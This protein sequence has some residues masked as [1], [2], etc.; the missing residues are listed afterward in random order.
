M[1]RE[2]LGLLLRWIHIIAGIMWV[3]DSLLFMW[4]DSHLSPDPQR[5]SEV[6]GVTWLIHGGGYYH[7]EK[8]LLVPGR[9]PPRL[10]W[11]WLEA[12]STWLSGFLLLILIYYMSADAYLIDRS[13]SSI[14]PAAAT[15]VGVG[16]IVGGW[17]LYYGLW[18]TP[19]V[20]RPLILL[21]LSL[22]LLAAAG[23]LAT[24]VLSARAA[25]LHIGAMLG[26]IMAANVWVHI[27]PPQYRMVQAARAG[28]EIDY[29]LGVHA[30]TRS[31]H[32]TYFTFPV[33]F[34]MISQHFPVVFTAQPAWLVLILFFVLGA[35]AR[36]IM[37]VGVRPA[38][39]IAAATAAALVIL[40]YLTARPVLSQR[41]TPPAVYGPVPSLSQV[42]A[43]LVERCAVCHSETPVMPGFVAPPVNVKMDTPQQI[44]ALAARI[45]I[46]AV[47]QRTMP[48]GNIT[49]I[50]DEE[51]ALLRRWIDAGAPLK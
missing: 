4:I 6:A 8:R 13:V 22:L 46:R 44:R 30:K 11:F 27:L 3:G 18:C 47:E 32:N 19:L 36:H 50:T 26:T 28:R 10:R 15:A 33:I 1:L 51:R 2:W 14:T 9:L 34:L 21:P 48:P 25:F 40:V 42:R 49:H 7:L 12:T 5:R 23:Y 16:L 45:K 29:S 38:R 37:L 17:L 24:H 35:G 43:V 20:N 31:T 41:S 39:T